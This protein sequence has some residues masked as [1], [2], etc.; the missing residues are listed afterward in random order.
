M[1]IQ[2]CWMLQDKPSALAMR[3]LLNAAI[4]VAKVDSYHL[5]MMIKRSIIIIIKIILAIIIIGM[6][7]K[8]TITTL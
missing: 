3:D 4:D 1:L 8:T 7:L 6:T 5:M 2:H